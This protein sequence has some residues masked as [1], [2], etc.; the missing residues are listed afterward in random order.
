MRMTVI[1]NDLFV[2]FTDYCEIEP[3][4][5]DY[6]LKTGQVVGF[7]DRCAVLLMP[8]RSLIQHRLDAL[9]AVGEKE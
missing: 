1:V 3:G 2:E 5:W 7:M 6:V 9:R 4:K 8:D